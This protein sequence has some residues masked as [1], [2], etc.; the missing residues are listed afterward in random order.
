MQIE[1]GTVVSRSTRVAHQQLTGDDGSV[2]LDLDTAEYFG[3]DPV[4][5]VIWQLIGDN[6]TRFADLVTGVRTRLPDAPPDVDADVAE[7]LE[8]MAER[9]LVALASGG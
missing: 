9:R 3:L 6:G 5:T 4:G 2:I 7:F 8:A 1:P